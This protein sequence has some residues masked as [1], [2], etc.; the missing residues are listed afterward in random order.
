MR[1]CGKE[2][3]KLNFKFKK[4]NKRESDRIREIRMKKK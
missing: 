3:L 4:K 1:K 2:N